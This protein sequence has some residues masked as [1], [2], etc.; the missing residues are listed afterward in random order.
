MS[1]IV[2]YAG[3][4]YYHTLIKYTMDAV[5]VF[6]L[7]TKKL[8]FD[9]LKTVACY[10]VDIEEN[11]TLL[12]EFVDIH[13]CVEKCTFLWRLSSL[14]QFLLE[15]PQTWSVHLVGCKI[16]LDLFVGDIPL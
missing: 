16:W 12:M 1:V 7:Q 11:V 15:S 4:L 8:V 10:S 2:F 6:Q 13:E 14:L 9:C 3:P 5:I